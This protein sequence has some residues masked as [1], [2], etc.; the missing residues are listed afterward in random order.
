MIA[1]L[2]WYWV[3]DKKQGG[4]DGVEGVEGVAEGYVITAYVC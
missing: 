4:N 2:S 1:Q 3:Q